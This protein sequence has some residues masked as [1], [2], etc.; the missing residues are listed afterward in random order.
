MLNVTRHFLLLLRLEYCEIHVVLEYKNCSVVLHFICGIFVILA[1]FHDKTLNKYTQNVT[2]FFTT[3]LYLYGFPLEDNFVSSCLERSYVIFN[4]IKVYIL[5][6]C[7]LLGI[8]NMKKFM[9]NLCLSRLLTFT[10][11]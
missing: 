10:F 4:A 5:E 2:K 1:I 6:K 11:G 3:W 9:S 7:S 8:I